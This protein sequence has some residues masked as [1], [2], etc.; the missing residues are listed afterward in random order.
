MNNT[1]RFIPD[2]GNHY[3]INEEGVIKRV[4]RIA[5]S[6]HQVWRLFK[7]Q[8]IKVNQDSRSGYLIVKLSKPDGSYGSQYV[9]R[10]VAKTFIPNTK[11]K[12][13]V[14]HKD[15]NKLNPFVDNLE[16]VTASENQLHAIKNRLA[17]IPGENARPVINICTGVLYPSIKKAASALQI[18]YYRCKR[19][20]NNP[21]LNNTCLQVA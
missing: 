21:T 12:P 15:G 5:I 14:N 13:F 2:Y 20:I 11:N 17:K 18:N 4:E 10:L 19:I 9:H 1:F 3:Q 7:E 6:R 8:L 16:W